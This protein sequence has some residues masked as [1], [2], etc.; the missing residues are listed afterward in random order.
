MVSVREKRREKKKAEEDSAEAKVP[1]QSDTKEVHRPEVVVQGTAESVVAEEP[2]AKTDVQTAAPQTAEAE[3]TIMPSWGTIEESEWMY[4]I[5]NRNED[6]LLWAEE[7]SDFILKWM[8]QKHLHTL[9]VSVF[10]S[11]VPFKDIL[12]KTEVFKVLAE[13]LISQE[14]A[15]WLDSKHRQLRVYWKP[16]EDWADRIYEWALE[17]GNTLLDV[18]TLVIQER[19]KDFASL[20][21]RDL[22]IVLAILVRREQAD[23]VDE[24]KGAVR[25]RIDILT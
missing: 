25:I 1:L 23:W 19:D 6:K 2:I 16:L 3:I 17:T 8:E 11:E 14:I 22:H 18:Q 15:E 10:V 12:G 9:S 24:K 7:W 5:P 21:E 13:T 4:S 20:P